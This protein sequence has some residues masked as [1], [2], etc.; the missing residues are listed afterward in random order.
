MKTIKRGGITYRLVPIEEEKVP[1]NRPSEASVAKK[2]MKDAVPEVSG[3]R[4]RFKNKKITLEDVKA[5][6]RMLK[7]LP[8]QDGELDKYIDNGRL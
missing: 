5:P 3:Y 2:G 8:K 4:E 7:K 1:Q 6:P